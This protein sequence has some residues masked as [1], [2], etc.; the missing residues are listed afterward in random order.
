M[1]LPYPASGLDTYTDASSH[2]IGVY[3]DAFAIYAKIKS[4]AWSDDFNIGSAEAFAVE[5]AL[6]HLVK[7]GVKRTSFTFR[8]DNMGVVDGW[9]A[10]RS[11]NVPTNSCFIRMIALCEEHELDLELVY[12]DT[13][14]N[15]ADRVSRGD[16]AGLQMLQLPPL[17]QEVLKCLE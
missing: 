8:V 10:R 17:Q 4:D 7:Q 12:V 13:K 11:R 16:C 15:K 9:S 6:A 14:L 5:I 3:F 2:G 1:R